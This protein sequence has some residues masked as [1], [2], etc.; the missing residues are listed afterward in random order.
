MAN[1]VGGSRGPKKQNPVWKYFKQ[2]QISGQLWSMCICPVTPEKCVTTEVKVVT[3]P[4][5]EIIL[6]QSTPMC[7]KDF[8]KAEE[9]KESEK[10]N[11]Y[12]R[13][14]V[15]ESLDSFVKS[16]TTSGQGDSNAKPYAK[17]SLKY[18]ALKEKLT[19]LAVCTTV[20]Q[21]VLQTKEFKSYLAECDPMAAASIPSQ[22][23]LTYWVMDYS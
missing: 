15:Q 8:K 12:A 14:L 17:N 16:A 1:V 4:T 21:N 11:K 3:I 20:S 22:P 7:S 6:R 5:V 2:E 13:H 18:S 9:K 10:K 23:V 19:I